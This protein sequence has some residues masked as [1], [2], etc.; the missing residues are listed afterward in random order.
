M[1]WIDLSGLEPLNVRALL[2]FTVRAVRV[3]IAACLT[4]LEPLVRFTLT[5]LATLGVFVTIVFGFLLKAKNFPTWFMLGMALGCLADGRL[6]VLE[7]VT[8]AKSATTVLLRWIR[9]HEPRLMA[10]DL[11]SRGSNS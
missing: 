7:V 10:M 8:K 5:R 2:M 11:K 9:Q 3:L 4:L 6:R 1:R